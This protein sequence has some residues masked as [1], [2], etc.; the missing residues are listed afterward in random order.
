MN[1]WLNEITGKSVTLKGNYWDKQGVWNDFAL[2]NQLFHVPV[3]NQ[4]H[5]WAWAR[6]VKLSLP[7]TQS[8][9]THQITS[10]DTL[11]PPCLFNYF[12]TLSKLDFKFSFSWRPS[13]VGP[14][15]PTCWVRTLYL[16]PH[17][18]VSFCIY[19]YSTG[20]ALP[21][22]VSHK[23]FK[24]RGFCKMGPELRAGPVHLRLLGSLLIW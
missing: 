5:R 24:D 4:F 22:T 17:S 13:H 15:T 19:N 18:S 6:M 21:T 11:S 10:Y 23:P 16:L 3:Y 20:C 2:D 7:G 8:L 12:C 14:P 1:A 9:H